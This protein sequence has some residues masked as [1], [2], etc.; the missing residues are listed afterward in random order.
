MCEGCGTHIPLPRLEAE[1]Q[2]PDGYEET[3]FVSRDI[4]GVGV[5]VF[6]SAAPGHSLPRFQDSLEDVGHTGFLLDARIMAGVLYHFLT[7]A[8]YREAVKE[9]HR[10]M[11]GLFEQYLSGLRGA[12]GSEVTVS[13]K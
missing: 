7:D 4:P 3:G 5:G 9:E 13:S 8:R 12:Y 1:P 10:V 6:T 2:R 11:S